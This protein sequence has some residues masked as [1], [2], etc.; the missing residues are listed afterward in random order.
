MSRLQMEENAGT[1]DPTFNETGVVIYPADTRGTSKAILALPQGKLLVAVATPWGEPNEGTPSFTLARFNEDGTF[2]SRFGSRGV[3]PVFFE[4][5]YVHGKL[6][7]TASSN[8]GWVLF[9]EYSTDGFPHFLGVA[10]VRQCEDGTLDASFGEGGGVFI[11]YGEIGRPVMPLEDEQ[12]SAEK[13][14]TPWN[15]GNAIVE[16][17]DGKLIFSSRFWTDSREKG[18]LLRLNRDGSR[19]KT[20]NGGAVIVE[21]HGVAHDGNKIGAIAVQKDDKVLVAGNYWGDQVGIYIAR[22]DAQGQVDASF[23]NGRPVIIPVAHSNMSFNAIAVRESDGGIVAVS[24]HG[25]IVVLNTTGSYNQVFNNGKPLYSDLPILANHWRRCAWQA[26]GAIVVINDGLLTINSL[27][28]TARYNPDGTPDMKFNGQG[29]AAF[30][31]ED[32]HE[33]VID[34]VIMKNGRIVVCGVSRSRGWII[35]YLA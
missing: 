33:S 26:D 21:L 30:N 9:G 20:F 7:L 4:N 25:L 1:L 2:D 6:A 5:V 8:G 19:D 18:I 3:L 16:Q 35:R 27:A 31:Y 29:W 10:V 11:P 13:H 28:V 14:T 17:L 32:E 12:T 24:D 34:M 23:N 15:Q 22:Y